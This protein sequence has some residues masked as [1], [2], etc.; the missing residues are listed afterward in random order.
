[1]HIFKALKKTMKGYLDDQIP[2]LAA[3]LSFYSIL[4]LA[5]LL[6]F[7][8]AISSLL[9]DVE[10]IKAELTMVAERLIGDSGS[11]VIA[12]LMENARQPLQR[13]FSSFFSLL[14]LAYG[15]TGVVNQLIKS[16]NRIFGEGRKGIVG[17][18]RRR[19]SSLLIMLGMA[20]LLFVSFIAGGFLPELS[21]LV[22]RSHETQMLYVINA[23]F[24][25]MMT[26][27]LFAM[28]YKVMPDKRI[29]WRRAWRGAVFGSV[30]FAI[31]RWVLTLYLG[32]A[33]PGSVYGAAGS[34]VVLLIWIYYSSQILLM[35]AEFAKT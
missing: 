34:V 22:F 30:L 16:L 17:T 28:T 29:S 18:I 32:I 20:M 19:F 6:V 2:E 12:G 31:G 3:S 23:M 9:F 1:V 14:I 7:L 24:S 27:G 11:E 4:S 21:V 33:S 10:F 5:P 8:L 26:L 25:F 15:A 13:S 35:G